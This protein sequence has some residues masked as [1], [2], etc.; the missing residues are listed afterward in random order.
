VNNV[1]T[2]GQSGTHHN[3]TYAVDSQDDS[4]SFL[5]SLSMSLYDMYTTD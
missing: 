4:E 2:F 5:F 1:H 3:I